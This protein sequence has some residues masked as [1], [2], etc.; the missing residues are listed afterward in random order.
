[1]SS[2]KEDTPILIDD[3]AFHYGQI[4]SVVNFLNKDGQRWGYNPFLL[5]GYPA[6][7]FLGEDQM[8]WE[9]FVY[10]LSPILPLGVS[11]KLYVGLFLLIFPFLCYFAARNF[12]MVEQECY[13]TLILGILIFYI[14]V[15]Y[16][17]KYPLMGGAAM[18]LCGMVAYTF[19]C[20]LSMYVLSVLHKYMENGGV[21]Q[22][23]LLFV[24]LP[25]LCLTHALAPVI[26]V[27]PVIVILFFYLRNGRKRN[28]LLL[29]LL[30]IWT[31]FI[32]SYYWIIP[33]F[34]FFEYKRPI[35]S[36]L[37][38]WA[39]KSVYFPYEFYVK[40]IV[41]G[42][43]FYT[44]ILLTGL[45]GLYLL[46][47]NKKYKL[48]LALCGQFVFLFFLYFYGGFFFLTES[49]HPI[50]YSFPLHL[51]LI[52]PS[53]ITIHRILVKPIIRIMF[54]VVFIFSISAP[55]RT[56]LIKPLFFK[57]YYLL[58]T[59]PPKAV[60]ELCEWI[61]EHTTSTGRILFQ[62][63]KS[64]FD[65]FSFLE[66]DSHFTGLL[67]I[68]T[69]RE[70][71]AGPIAMP[72]ENPWIAHNFSTF[73]EGDLFWRSLHSYSI[74]E[75]R[76]YFDLYNICWIICWSDTS[77]N[78]FERY[79]EYLKLTKKVG[80]FYI[81]T[82]FRLPSFF[83]KGEGE[84]GSDYNRLFLNNIKPQDDEIIIKYH[85]MKYLKTEPELKMEKVMLLDD[86][87]GFIK[88]KNPPSSLVIY[89][90]Y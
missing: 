9:L 66:F 1:L 52:F 86:P 89:N 11:F 60:E 56:F 5:A 29:T 32:N 4:V 23:I 27:V 76:S 35:A 69:N 40:S 62:D 2:F 44:L 30:S 85:W 55:L 88:I 77:R 20:Y 31:I 47:R 39:H 17:Y 82:V 51:F 71:I 18:I 10:I 70:F 8:A 73:C 90:A 22:L 81:Y 80:N 28:Y 13:I 34:K 72:K 3:Y 15:V 48:A 61:R 37:P 7:V 54:V 59:E 79:P 25:L 78:V 75:L 46:Y 84:I 87:V 24:F 41:S 49:I 14:P 16:A 33:L 83:I 38:N 45:I 12:G 63:T 21:T 26:L 74:E 58:R 68:N 53:A 64:Q 67:P 36:I 6:P 65:H 43:I 50:R 57:N 42:D 19:I